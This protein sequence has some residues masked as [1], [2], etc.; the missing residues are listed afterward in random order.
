MGYTF[1]SF[2]GKD[3]D[4]TR[5]EVRVEVGEGQVTAVNVKTSSAQVVFDAPPLTR[6]VQAWVSISSDAYKE[7]ELALRSGATIPYR[8][9]QYRKPGQDRKTPIAELRANMQIA[10]ESTKRVFASINNGLSGE[11]VTNPKEDKGQGSNGRYVATDDDM[12][13]P[14]APTASGSTVSPD[15]LI[16]ALR[17]LSELNPDSNILAATIGVAIAL[18]AD[19]TEVFKVA[20]GKDR[21]VENEPQPH[22]QETF[23]QEAPGWKEWNSDGRQNLG[24]LRFS[25]GVSAE[26]FTRAEL[27]DAKSVKLNEEQLEEAINFFSKLILSIAD[28]VQ[29]KAYGQGSRPDRAAASHSRIRGIVY[30]TIKNYHNIPINLEDE[31]P[32][33][34]IAQWIGEVGTLAFQRFEIGL[35]AS[36]AKMSFSDPLPLSIYGAALEKKNA[37]NAK[38]A[39]EVVNAPKVEKTTQQLP[40][41]EETVTPVEPEV[42]ENWAED[43]A[44]FESV[45]VKSL[46]PEKQRPLATKESRDELMNF[47]KESGLAVEDYALVGN[48]LK[49]TFGEE[50][51]LSTK[52]PDPLLTDFLDF[53][54]SAGEE[55]FLAVLKSAPKV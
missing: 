34:T 14:G 11:G 28:R 40:V 35:E 18:G 5:A 53:Y 41:V 32:Q 37:A 39:N 38:K 26:S 27:T 10:N 49:F 16:N 9:E 13:A 4:G 51:S 17:G 47:V 50:Y 48:L 29:T 31:N 45:V 2:D 19:P 8:I 22:R 44:V 21:A 1:T 30:D 23:A 12:D 52:V 46:P 20:G 25:S 33:H 15:A 54:I 24:H 43:L 55:N 42:N 36:N 6:P 7:A 3:D